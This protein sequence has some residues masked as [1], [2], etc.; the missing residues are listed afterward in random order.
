MTCSQWVS[1]DSTTL[2]IALKAILQM[3]TSELQVVACPPGLMALCKDRSKLLC[4]LVIMIVRAS[5]PILMEGKGGWG[6]KN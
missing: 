1:K 3:I 5:T 6:E 4:H 2:D